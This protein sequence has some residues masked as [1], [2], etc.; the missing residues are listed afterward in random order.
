MNMNEVDVNS[1]LKRNRSIVESAVKPADYDAFWKKYGKC[2]M[3]TLRRYGTLTMSKLIIR[4]KR[5][6]ARLFRR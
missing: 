6:V 3:W 1:V 2:P 5:T 4:A